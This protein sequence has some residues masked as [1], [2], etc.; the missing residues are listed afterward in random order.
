MSQTTK[1]AFAASIKKLSAHKML[2][3]ITVID[4]AEDCEVN[5]QT[6]YYHFKDIFDLVEW[7]FKSEST[8][9]IDGNKTYDTWQNGY[10]QVF[11]YVEL[12]H[13]FVFSVYH[14]V[15]RTHLEQFLYEETFALLMSV[16]NEK[17]DCMLVREEDKKFI[18]DFYKYA[19]VGII[20]EWIRTGMKENPEHIIY[21]LGIL[22]QGDISKALDKYQK[23][24]KN[25]KNEN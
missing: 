19:F 24:S 1:R 6:F 20:L 21:H 2:D 22:I 14:S 25:R 15:C 16:V 17:A 7:I 9:A 11:R 12:N 8:R 3:K 10:L 18:A 5:R 23:D 13:D 4:I